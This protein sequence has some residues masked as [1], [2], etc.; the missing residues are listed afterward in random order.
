MKMS[1]QEVQPQ[2]GGLVSSAVLV[3]LNISMWA[4]RKSAKDVTKKVVQENNATASDAAH[5]TKKLFVDNPKFA[6]I[7]KT[8]SKI[9]NYVLQHT[10]PWM[11]DMRLLPVSQ[12][13]EFTEAMDGM[14]KEFDA[15]VDD[16]LQGYAVAVRAMA[17]KLGNLFDRDEYPSP[18]VVRSKFR[19]EWTVAPVPTSGDFRVDAENALR[20]ELAEHYQKAMDKRVADAMGVMWERLHE[21]L[22]HL[23]DRLAYGDDGKPN[24]FRDSMLDNAHELLS[25]LRSLNITND[26]KMEAAR[27]DLAAALQGV[28]AQ[29]LRKNEAVR[30]DV[31]A[32]VSE[33]LDKFSF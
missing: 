14:A 33:I 27:A 26:A 11:G 21:T 6:A 13:L 9:R 1:A 4:G 18:D 22:T 3:D 15:A 29:E 7:G 17:F 24:I 20:T 16:F 32:R 30:E 2:V 12:Y 5:V 28:E 19:V 10:L 8:G 23:K 31:R 25:M